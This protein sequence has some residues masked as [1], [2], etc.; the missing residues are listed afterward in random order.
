MQRRYQKRF[1]LLMCGL[2]HFRKRP[3]LTLDCILCN[4]LYI[5]SQFWRVF[6]L[7][8]LCIFGC[9]DWRRTSK[10]SIQY[11]SVI[12]T[13]LISFPLENIIYEVCVCICFLKFNYI[14]YWPTDIS[15]RTTSNY[16]KVTGS[17]NIEWMKSVF[18]SKICMHFR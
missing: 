11:I 15:T 4:L 17:W 12:S 1:C 7:C 13:N 3:A 18:C 8:V 10:H 2:F 5:G 16:W 14:I 9:Y 6:S